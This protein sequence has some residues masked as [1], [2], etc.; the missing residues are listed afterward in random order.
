MTNRGAGNL[1]GN[2]SVLLGKDDGTFQAPVNY[3]ADLSPV[4]VAVGDFNGDG[5]PDLAI[6]NTDSNDISVLLGNGDGTFQAA[7]N[8][9]TGGNPV[10]LAIADF[11]GDG[12]LDLVVA[13]S[14][15]ASVSVLSGNGD[16]TF[17]S[18]LDF[19]MSS[20]PQTEPLGIST[21]IADWTSWLPS[22]VAASS[23]CWGMAT[24]H[25]RLLSIQREP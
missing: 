11:N 24:G 25:F 7:S 16:G 1:S 20:F 18:A 6:V 4:A 22:V 8:F 17:Q 5:K 15:G 23:D 12:K 10:A 9:D 3:A 13:N 19:P 21:A 2:V 14:S